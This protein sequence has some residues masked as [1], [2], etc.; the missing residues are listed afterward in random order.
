MLLITSFMLEEILILS[1]STTEKSEMSLVDTQLIN[2]IMELI[3]L[4]YIHQAV[5]IW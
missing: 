3:V 5:M 4:Q 2:S 1:K